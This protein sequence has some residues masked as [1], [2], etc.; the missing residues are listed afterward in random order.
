MVISLELIDFHVKN[1]DGVIVPSS[2]GCYFEAS[3]NKPTLY[4]FEIK[5]NKGLPIAEN[6]FYVLPAIAKTLFPNLS[7]SQINWVISAGIRQSQVNCQEMHGYFYRAEFV[8]G[9][10][11]EARYFSRPFETYRDAWGSKEGYEQ[12]MSSGH[13]LYRQRT[14]S[15]IRVPVPAYPRGET[16]FQENGYTSGFWDNKVVLVSPHKFMTDWAKDELEGSE[17]DRYL[18]DSSVDTAIKHTWDHDIAEHCKSLAYLGHYG[19]ERKIRFVNGRHRTANLATLG[20]PFLPVEVSMS[21]ESLIEFEQTYAWRG[22]NAPYE[23]L[24]NSLIE[25]SISRFKKAFAKLSPT[26]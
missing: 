7:V 26:M 14:A 1:S 2:C 16:F 22:E 10:T 23:G 17:Y 11:G 5:E 21:P 12:N 8:D 3:G 18:F 4:L 19:A 20:A 13:G 15:F 25:K 6:A 9:F 24:N